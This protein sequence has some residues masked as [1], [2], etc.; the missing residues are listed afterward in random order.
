MAVIETYIK[1]LD[2]SYNDQ[3]LD[4][5]RSS[6][7]ETDNLYLHFDKSPDIFLPNE[8]WSDRFQYY[9]IF[10]G[11]LLAG[12]GMHLKYKGFVSGKINDISY[13]GNF[14]I[15]K[16]FRNQGLFKELSEFMLNGLYRDTSFGYCLILEGNQSAL[17]Y[18]MRG[19]RTLPSMPYYIK[20]GSY[21]TRNI[22]I[23]RKRRE[24]LK[25]QIRKAVNEDITQIISMLEDAYPSRIL[26]SVINQDIFM[27]RLE[28]RPDFGISNYYLAFEKGILVGLCAAWDIS[29]FKR[30]RILKYK[31]WFF[32]IRL[33][34]K[35][36]SILFHYPDLP[37]QG[38]SLREVYLTDLV[39]KNRNPEVLKN[40]LIPIYN[41]YRAK[42]YNLIYFG[43]YKGDPLLKAASSFFSK[44]LYSNIYFSAKDEQL[45]EHQSLDFSKSLIDLPLVG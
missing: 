15:D 16:R 22:L 2:H 23:T 5:L 20:I 34:Y 6:P 39:I 31:K 37:D 12:F 35:F 26:S 38:G 24:N 28:S 30:T 42:K 27:N 21:E 43:S 41:E 19:E 32:W 4:I 14:C 9:G 1:E 11:D 29:S 25:Y 40:L 33:L 44:P 17:K 10:V 7:M 3:M 18:F 13:F 8:L 45:L 36:I